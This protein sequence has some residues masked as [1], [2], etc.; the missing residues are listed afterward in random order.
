MTAWTEHLKE[1]AAKNNMTYKEA[2]KDENSKTLYNKTKPATP[3]KEKK[4]PKEKKEPK[5]KK[6]PKEKKAP[7]E[8]NKPYE[9]PPGKSGGMSHSQKVK[10]HKAPPVVDL[11]EEEN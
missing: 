5:E 10:K 4:S 11:D 3:P 6:P 8:K 9:T 2:M 7:K 1:Y